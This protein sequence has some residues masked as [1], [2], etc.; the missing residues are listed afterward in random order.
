MATTQ[1]TTPDGCP[2]CGR[3]VDDERSYRRHL[4]DV[5]EPSEL[6]AI[7]RRRYEQYQPTPNAAV[8]AGSSLAAALGALR[9]PVDGSTMAFY[10]V[11][12]AAASLVLAAFLGVMS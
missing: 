4:H 9:Y 12:G 7:D 6:G 3:S 11:Y 10:A 2:Y 1:R 5:H 8:R